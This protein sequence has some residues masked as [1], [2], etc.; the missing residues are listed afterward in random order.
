MSCDQGAPPPYAYVPGGPW[1]RPTGTPP[2]RSSGPIAGDDWPASPG[3]LHGVELFNAGY[4]WEAHEAWEALWHAHGR[5]GATADLIKGLIK[6][7]AAGVKVGQGQRPGVVTH[8]RR[9]G[10]CF[11]AAR[12]QGGGRRLGLDLGALIEV[13]G[14]VAGDPPE[15]PAPPGAAVSRVFGFRIEPG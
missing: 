8:A 10:E 15:D 11:E 9:A 1:P 4:Y 3:Y 2:D 5:R 12:M 6:L 14:A 13:A 7:A